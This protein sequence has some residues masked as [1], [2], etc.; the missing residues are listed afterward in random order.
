M[1]LLSPD[2]YLLPPRAGSLGREM[3]VVK[4]AISPSF[5]IFIL[6]LVAQ[7]DSHLP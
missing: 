2:S 6:F 7:L 3:G 1:L 4:G 5:R